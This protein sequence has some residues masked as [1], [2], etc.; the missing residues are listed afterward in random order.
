MS[1]LPAQKNV[2]KQQLLLLKFLPAT[3]LQV[4]LAKGQ[5][6]PADVKVRFL[7]ALPLFTFSCVSTC[8]KML[9]IFAIVYTLQKAVNFILL[10]N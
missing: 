10:L 3:H 2:K 4:Q 9:A 5:N 8:V 7:L 1:L 6:Q